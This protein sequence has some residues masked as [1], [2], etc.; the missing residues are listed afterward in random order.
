MFRKNMK[1]L[2][3]LVW[4]TGIMWALSVLFVLYACYIQ[5]FGWALVLMG[6]GVIWFT[7]FVNFA[8]IRDDYEEGKR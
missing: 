3:R 6:C 1:N 7:A 4:F 2:N 8:D 5:S